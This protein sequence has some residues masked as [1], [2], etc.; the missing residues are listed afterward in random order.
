MISL[1]ILF[2]NR[3]GGKQMEQIKR[4]PAKKGVAKET[5][6]ETRVV[7]KTIVKKTSEKKTP[8]LRSNTE[9]K[10]S[11]SSYFSNEIFNAQNPTSLGENL[12]GLG[13][14]KQIFP[15]ALP[16]YNLP[17]LRV[18]SDGFVK[19]KKRKKHNQWNKKIIASIILSSLIST[20]L[21]FSFVYRPGPTF[22]G[23]TTNA[24][25]LS[26]GVV[27]TETE[28]RA[29]VVKLGR[30]VFWA[31][32][33]VGAKYTLNVSAKGEAFVR[34]LPDG[35]GVSDTQPKYRVIGTYDVSNAYAET[36]GAGN[37]SNGVTFTNND[38]AI[39]YYNKL[40]PNNV[41]LAFKD[42]DFQIEVF[43]PGTNASI[44]LVSTNKT[45]V[46]IS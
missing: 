9:L 17:E 32:P 42:S 7:K 29:L 13:F 4:S 45:I 35:R 22:S 1:K 3:E 33:L 23:Q 24:A 46:P 30:P 38:G 36:V 2:K 18:S 43:D 27:L 44:K 5:E 39:V 14:E 12:S 40:S 28:L 26:G 15:L 16:S 11:F 19:E 21:T 41:Y 34:Y 10:K 31:G 25:K 6:A 20:G 8:P 37:E